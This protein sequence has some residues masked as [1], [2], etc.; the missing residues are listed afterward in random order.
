MTLLEKRIDSIS[1][2]LANTL[3]VG[4]T[5]H[6]LLTIDNGYF[7][8]QDTV[9]RIFGYPYSVFSDNLDT[10]NNWTGTWAITTE[11]YYSPASSMTDSPNGN[12][13][14]G[15]NKS[16]ALINEINLPNTLLMVLEFRAKWALEKDYDY[17]Q[18]SISVNNGATWVPLSGKYTRPGTSNQVPGQ[19]LYDGKEGDWLREAISLNDYMGKK[20]KFRFRLK[21]DQGSE[22]DGFYFDDFNISMLLDP[23]LLSEIDPLKFLLGLPYPNPSTSGFK[24]SYA[25]PDTKSNANLVITTASGTEVSKTRLSEQQG[26]AD[27]D[28]RFLS[29]G[30]YFMRVESDIFQSQVRKLIIKK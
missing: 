4:D 24:V 1:Y 6:Y 7:T 18:V 2:E 9:M 28:I 23:T 30:I 5:I 10:K 15:A 11:D 14:A 16:I 8:E 29:P 26:L 27:I 22:Q 13:S 12:Y 20:V 17:V 21:A 25:L 19:P 3:Q